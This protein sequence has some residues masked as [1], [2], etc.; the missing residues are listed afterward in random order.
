MHT[1]MSASSPPLLIESQLSNDHQSSEGHQVGLFCWRAG[2]SLSRVRILLLKSISQEQNKTK[3]R[4]K[5]LSMLDL[6]LSYKKLRSISLPDSEVGTEHVFPTACTGRRA[7]VG[8]I[9]T[10]STSMKPVS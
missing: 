9:R 4:E 1:C 2:I 3:T 10:K 5:V 8:L 6:A 7:R